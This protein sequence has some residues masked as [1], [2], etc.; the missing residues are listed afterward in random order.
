M[1]VVSDTDI[2]SWLSYPDSIDVGPDN[3]LWI[4][5]GYDATLGA[6]ANRKFRKVD[7]AAPGTT[8]LGPFDNPDQLHVRLWHD[9]VNRLWMDT[10]ASPAALVKMNDVTGAEVSRVVSPVNFPMG[11][12]SDGQGGAFL[13]GFDY[14]D[15]FQIDLAGNIV[16]TIKQPAKNCNEL[17]FDHNDLGLYAVFVEQGTIVKYAVAGTPTTVP[18]ATLAIAIDAVFELSLFGE[19][20]QLDVLNLS[21]T[22]LAMAYAT[23]L[24]L[25]ARVRQYTQRTQ[26]GAIGNPGL[27]LHDRITVAAPSQ[28]IAA[29][30]YMIRS[31]RSDQTA[32]AGTYLAVLG[33]EPAAA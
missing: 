18:T 33:L 6:N 8:L 30:D 11:F 27:Q 32:D 24:S 14:I 5:D 4:A 20:R 9:Q 3:H 29:G 10:Y 17:A 2:S 15:L 13:T 1:A 28:G 25:L 22:D 26:S 16:N 21:I 23:A 7:R 19:I 12:D 31:I